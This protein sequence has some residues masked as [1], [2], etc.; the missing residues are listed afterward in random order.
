MKPRAD[1]ACL[2]K[3]CLTED[4]EAMVYE[5]PVDAT[6]CPHGHKRLRRLF[7]KVGVI[8]L[9]DTQPDPDS[10][11]TSSSR[12]ARSQPA[13]QSAFDHA[14]SHKLSN[15]GMRSYELHDAPPA[16]RQTIAAQLGGQSGKGR[17]MRPDEIRS[18][19]ARDRYA[20]SSIMAQQW[21]HGIPSWVKS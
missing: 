3:R 21:G 7:N 12:F 17:P 2:S 4:G 9:R 18:T 13:L 6:H 15:P 20:P 14:D 19:L 1:H 10:R 16:V 11:L 8:G 5:L